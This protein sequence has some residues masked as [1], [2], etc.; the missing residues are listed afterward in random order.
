MACV[1]RARP[2]SECPVERGIRASRLACC[3]GFGCGQVATLPADLPYTV[4][5]V[6][7]TDEAPPKRQG[8]VTARD[9]AQL[10]GVSQATVSYIF[11]NKAGR[12]RVGEDTRQR[13]LEAA[14]RLGYHPNAAARTLRTGKTGLVALVVPDLSNST[15]PT[16]AVNIQREAARHNLDLLVYNNPRTEGTDQVIASLMRRQVDGVVLVAQYLSEA[17]QDA[18]ASTGLPMVAVGGSL[19]HPQI[20]RVANRDA[21]C[22]RQAVQ[23]LI[24]R[25]HQKIAHLSG[26]RDTFTGQER[27]RGYLEALQEAGLE[28]DPLWMLEGNYLKGSAG[29][30]VLSLMGSANP[31]EALFVANDVMAIDALLALQDAG[32]RIPEDLALVGFDDIPECELVRPR[33]T[34]VRRARGDGIEAIMGMLLERLSGFQ[35]PGRVVEFT[36]ELIVRDSG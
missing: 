6:N 1:S 20:D 33:L 22:A 9:V 12:S 7:P 4:E 16:F 11:S 30:L 31:P 25:G 21:E 27:K 36:G 8:T 26:P 18:L 28:A 17:E 10:A 15:Y 3:S 35:G 5:A 34:S 14:A 29:P 24:A 23:H 32:F 2:E 13:V 19:R